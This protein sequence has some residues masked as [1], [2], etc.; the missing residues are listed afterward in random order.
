MTTLTRLHAAAAAAAVVADDGETASVS[1]ASS[2]WSWRTPCVVPAAALGQI[3]R[4]E[5]VHARQ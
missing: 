4:P 2:C 1:P 5:R 3:V